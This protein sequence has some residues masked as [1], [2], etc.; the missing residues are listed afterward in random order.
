MAGIVSYGAYLPRLRLE[1]M[2]IMMSMGWLAPGLI[3]AAQGERT[4]CNWDEDSLTMAVAASR[5]CLVGQDKSKIEAAYLASTSLPFADRA[6]AGIMA[7]ALNLPG[8]IASLDS[9]G[10]QKAG[11]AALA[12]AIQ[13]VKSGERKNVLA[14]A[15]DHRRTK[16]AWFHEM[17]FGDGAASVLVGD[18]N[19]IAEFKGSYSVTHDF[20]DH[21]RG[22][23]AKYD[24]NWEERWIR[25]EGYMKAYAEAIGGLLKKTG[26][27]V[28]DISKFCYPCFLGRS[29]G[30][31]GKTL[32][33]QPAQVADNM[34]TVTGDCGTAHPLLML[35]RELETAKP[36][37]KIVV[38]SFGQGSDALLFQVTDKIKDLPKRRGMAGSLANKKPEKV[39]TK[40]LKFNDLIET[41]MGI[42]SEATIQTA[43]TTLY[44][45]RKLIL[46]FVGGKCA[47]CGTPQIPAQ[48]VCVKPGCGAVDS[49]EDYEFA[50]QPAKILTFTG[51]ML[52]VSVTP[53]AFYGMVQ[54]DHGGRMMMDF[55]DCDATEVEVGVPV[56]MSFRKK[57]IDAQ[58][59]FTG[60][61]WKAVPDKAAKA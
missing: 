44:R 47:K 35:C 1:R 9:T 31:I 25:D 40:F 57:Y 60:Y 7:T 6:N 15:S 28:A 19:V 22:S 38:A 14:T 33:A 45:N 34:H 41:E 59:G 21:Y 56:K 55:T 13:A 26:L 46:G 54:F 23:D 18:D 27:A 51:D 2:A 50:D 32:G 43:L 16:A 17:W 37:D 48:R 49:Q 24:Y 52:A 36:G 39:Y 42:R 12:A 8:E 53:P 5:D 29:H 20:I 11:T 3:T 10:T 30:T 58:R 61:F 4:M